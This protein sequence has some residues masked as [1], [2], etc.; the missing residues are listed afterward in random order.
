M[1][2]D[3]R[4]VRPLSREEDFYEKVGDEEESSSSKDDD[5]ESESESE[6]DEEGMD[7]DEAEELYDLVR[8]YQKEGTREI[9][10]PRV[11]AA[12]KKIKEGRKIRKRKESQMQQFQKFC[13]RMSYAKGFDSFIF[14]IVVLNITLMC[15]QTDDEYNF[16]G[17]WYYTLVDQVCFGIYIVE[18]FI[19]M[20][21]L[22]NEYFQD[23][24]NIL[25]FFVILFALMD[26]AP[27][28][29]PTFSFNSSALRAFR[30][31]RAVKAIKMMKSFRALRSLLTLLKSVTDSLHDCLSS[32]FLLLCVMYIF[33]FAGL[34]YYR[35]VSPENF[36][37]FF[38]AFFS[39][40]QLCTFDDWFDMYDQVK[41]A[42]GSG[43]IIF[44]ILF[45]ILCSFIILNYV[46][47]VLTDKACDAAVKVNANAQCIAKIR[48]M[49]RDLFENEVSKSNNFGASESEAE[50]RKNYSPM[51]TAKTNSIT[52]ILALIARI[53]QR[54]QILAGHL[55]VQGELIDAAVEHEQ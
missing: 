42:E 1:L 13:F 54:G 22:R 44:F 6:S 26:Y 34:T 31:F 21:G 24:F 25:D 37:D 19:K 40:F 30:V 39:M 15:I 38:A 18:M 29:L 7:S 52:E 33:A 23:K 14:L 32:M 9:E 53:E 17:K 47:A 55:A 16:N 27:A 20:Y 5:S 10:Q 49:H 8:K 45:M 43:H 28:I 50:V 4:K 35:E 48:K 2:K 3:M 41:V 51:S 12:I 46:T 11:K 36:G